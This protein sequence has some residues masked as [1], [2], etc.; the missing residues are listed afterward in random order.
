MK[1]LSKEACKTLILIA[2]VCAT[3]TTYAQNPIRVYNSVTV[4]R[5]DCSSLSKIILHMPYCESNEYQYIGDHRIGQQGQV[6]TTDDNHRYIW[7]K[8][9]N[10]ANHSGQITYRDT[11]DFVTTHFVQNLDSITTIPPYDPTSNEVLWYTG[12]EDVYITPQN[13]VIDSLANLIWVQSSNIIDYARRSYEYV[14]SHLTY[15]N[16]NTGLHSIEDIIADGGGDCG[17]FASFYIS[18][19]RNKGIPSRHV[20]GFSP[21]NGNDMHVWAEFYLQGYGWVPADPTY[22][23][24][25]PNG[26]YF[27]RYEYNYCIA[28]KGINHLYYIDGQS[29]NVPLLQLFSYWYW[30]TNTCNSVN[31]YRE[32]TYE[33]LYHIT[34]ETEDATYGH[35]VG[36]G[37]HVAGET[38][39]LEAVSSYGYTF[40]HWSNG[41]TENPLIF[42]VSG[43]SNLTAH[44]TAV[45]YDTVYI[46][47]TIIQPLTY[48]TLTIQSQDLNQGLVAG[49][50]HFPEGTEIEIAAIPIRGYRFTQWNDGS[51]QNPRSVILNEDLTLTAAFEADPAGIKDAETP[52]YQIG[53]QDG[54]IVVTNAAGQQIRVFDSVGRCLITDKGGDTTRI[55]SIPCSGTYMVQVGY[56][57]ARKVVVVK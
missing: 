44:Y 36:S 48:Y 43:D 11:F 35:V 25:D 46:H 19:L 2:I 38:A 57:A 28:G 20:I 4:D 12:S 21:Y 52:Y 31:T 10:F 3:W 30:Y 37:Y 26:D 24:S 18:I 17:N 22:K 55:F 51:A 29:Q 23:N 49:N 53:T 47:D 34:G 56:A 16:P 40:S 39:T 5:S 50:G 9:T 41:S 27:G 1:T 54:A 45:V 32:I 8:T 13:P 7:W 42:T 33:S 6:R 14:A 15:Q